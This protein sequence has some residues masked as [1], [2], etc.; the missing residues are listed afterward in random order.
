M[1]PGSSEEFANLLEHGDHGVAFSKM[2]DKLNAEIKFNRMDEFRMG[3]TETDMNVVPLHD[4]LKTLNISTANALSGSRLYSDIESGVKKIEKT[5]DK[6]VK[7]LYD[8]VNSELKAEEIPPSK[9]RNPE[10]EQAKK[11]KFTIAKEAKLDPAEFRKYIEQQEKTLADMDKYLAGKDALIAQKGGY[12]GQASVLGYNGER[13]YLAVL[14][15]RKS[16]L[17]NL[18]VAKN[19]GNNTLTSTECAWLRAPGFG[20]RT[21]LQ[22]NPAAYRNYLATEKAQY[23]QNMKYNLL[24]ESK[25]AREKMT[26]CLENE[27]K[28][29][30]LLGKKYAEAKDEK[31]KNEI[32]K[33]IVAS[34]EHTMYLEIVK[35]ITLSKEKEFTQNGL[36]T[37]EM[38]AVLLEE[39][40][41]N[42]KNTKGGA[43][44]KSYDTFKKDI[45]EK[46]PH[47]KAFDKMVLD[48]VKKGSLKHKDIVGMRNAFLNDFQAKNT[49]KKEAP[50]KDKQLA[51]PVAGGLRK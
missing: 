4:A 48:G 31:T 22:R 5:R 42:T 18:N 16:L 40:L 44:S 37:K 3:M 43:E 36:G 1:K 38:K 21:D 10:G 25:E 49:V 12:P 8:A 29:R 20:I 23:E 28:K 26:E 46:S 33:E 47:K 19:F 45:F 9:K 11:Y 34:A 50:V 17:C 14:N 7:K 39:L 32:G 2:K 27:E 35:D 41:S 13:R 6:F 51:N 24:Y 15:A 30:E